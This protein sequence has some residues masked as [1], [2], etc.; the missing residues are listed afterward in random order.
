MRQL[1]RLYRWNTSR[2]GLVPFLSFLLLI[3]LVCLV[4]GVGTG[5]PA[6]WV[7]GLLIIFFMVPLVFLREKMRFWIQDHLR[8]GRVQK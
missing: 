1:V 4:V 8:K 6:I 5:I 2:E 7:A 3:G